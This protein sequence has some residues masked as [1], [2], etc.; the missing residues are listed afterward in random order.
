MI[1][2]TRRRRVLAAGFAAVVAC[3]VGLAGAPAAAQPLLPPPDP[4]A[5]TQP[6]TPTMTQPG[7]AAVAQPA[8]ASGVPGNPAAAPP[9]L[10]AATSVTLIDFLKKKG[11]GLEPQNSRDFKALNI[12]LPMPQGWSLVPDP[13]VPDAFA[14]I[15]DRVGGD[16]LYTSNA[17]VVVYKLSGDFDPNEAI[18]HG[19]IDAAQQP[20][21]RPTKASLAEF[22]NY[23]SAAIEGTYRSNELTLNTSRRYLIASAGPDRYLV[24]LAVTTAADQVVSTGEATDAIVTGFHVGIPTA[25][26]RPSVPGLP[27]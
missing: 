11:V 8:S 3:V 24:S 9:T 17:Q 26:G 22:D 6:G 27:G 25:P 13:N 7:A 1:V 16:G 19:F 2:H 12:V 23:P 15:A 20:A 5:V 4:T 14:V 10:V 21:W 18:T